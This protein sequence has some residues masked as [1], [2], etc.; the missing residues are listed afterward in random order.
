MHPDP[1]YGSHAPGRLC[2]AVIGACHAMPVSW[3]GKRLALALRKICLKTR[4]ECLDYEIDGIRFRFHL[5]DNVGERKFLFMPQFF[6]VFERD[7]IRR[8]LNPGDTFI[9]IGANAGIY[10]LTAAAS[11]GG[12]GKVVA[13]E[14]NPV[15]QARLAFNVALNG[16]TECV[17]I[18]GVGISDRAG[19]FSLYL[20]H[21][22][23]G[24]SSLTRTHAGDAIEI[25][26][27]TLAELLARHGVTTPRMLKIDIEGAEDRALVP[28]FDAADPVQYPRHI[29]MENSPREW[30]LDLVA[31]LQNK[32]YRV[33][34]TTRMNL[35][36]SLDH[37][38]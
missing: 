36:L 8:H 35:V 1:E 22:N 15:M 11:M 34:R 2:R 31:Y 21:S 33:V 9:D 38:Y 30:D 4:A 3:L 28:F 13:V 19:S 29:I 5:R 6:D 7:Y 23:L 14:P 12:H 24:G 27:L 20:D 10:T 17:E 26:C 37:Y 32:G 25:Q 18:D 16:Y